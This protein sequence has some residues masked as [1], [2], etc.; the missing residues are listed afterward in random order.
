[1]S[2]LPFPPVERPASDGEVSMDGELVPA[3]LI[4]ERVP[5]DPGAHELV[6][7]A[8]QQVARK[9]VTAREGE[10]VTVSFQF[11]PLAPQKTPPASRASGA[12]RADE[13]EDPVRFRSTAPPRDTAPADT[14]PPAPF[15]TLRPPADSAARIVA[16]AS[17]AG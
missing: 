7:R 6:A 4:G 16:R 10:L 3:A 14:L 15:D 17:R 12:P 2:V 11:K 8:G 5:L 1:M 13:P 9:A